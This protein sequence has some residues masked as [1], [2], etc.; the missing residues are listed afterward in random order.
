[1]TSPLS[2]VSTTMAAPMRSPLFSRTDTRV[3]VSRVG[4]GFAESVVGGNRLRRLRQLAPIA[5]QQPREHRGADVELPL[6]LAFG[7]AAVG[8]RHRA[9]RSRQHCGQ[10][11]QKS[12][13]NAGAQRHYA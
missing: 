12:D 11:Q 13:G 3:S 2:E 6:H 5:L 9:E 4:D 1:M 7:I 8:G 10:Q